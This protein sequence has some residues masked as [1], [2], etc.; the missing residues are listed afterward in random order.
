MT[1]TTV[2]WHWIIT[3]QYPATDHVATLSG[4]LDADLGTRRDRMY[5][6][7]LTDVADQIPG[8]GTPVVLF[9]SIDPN[10]T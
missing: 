7:V 2:Q 5:A 10:D 3:V 1:V 9:F 4:V 8:H 6:H